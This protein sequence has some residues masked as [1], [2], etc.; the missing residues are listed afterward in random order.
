[1][2]AHLSVS[3]ALLN[4]RLVKRAPTAADIQAER[5]A[6]ADAVILPAKPAGRAP[7]EHDA[8]AGAASL[9]ADFAG[10]RKTPNHPSGFGPYGER[11]R[12]RRVYD[13]ARSRRRKRMMGGDGRLPNTLRHWFTEGERAVLSVIADEVKRRGKC[14]LMVEKLAAR[15]GVSIRL[16]Q[17]TLATASW[18]SAQILSLPVGDRPPLLLSIEYR[19]RKGC[20]SLPNV[21]TIL[22]REWMNWLS[23]RPSEAPAHE[24]AEYGD[25]SAVDAVAGRMHRVLGIGCRKKRTSERPKYLEVVEG[26]KSVDLQ[27]GWQR[28][29]RGL[30][31]QGAYEDES[32]PR[33]YRHDRRTGA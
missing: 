8:A 12:Q 9:P 19:P 7:A 2:S 17:Y 29:R 3:S 11:A 24:A 15:A 10:R 5:D 32:A 30:S 13:R 31:V 28:L 25:W 33:A 21:I 4:S 1:M 22:S 14:E 16:V 20:K 27:D 23:Y 26:C 18:R 6:A